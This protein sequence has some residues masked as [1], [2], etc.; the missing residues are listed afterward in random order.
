MRWQNDHSGQ[1]F[2]D[3]PIQFGI[4][5]YTETPYVPNFRL[6]LGEE[7]PTGAY[8]KLNPKRY[9]LDG[10]GQGVYSAMLGLNISKGFWSIPLH[11]VALRITTL[12]TQPNG[13]AHVK[14]LNA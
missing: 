10:S 14:G 9:G 5:L 4:E 3:F 8:Q 1:A 13:K 12:Y 7:F 6:V 11:P 2:G